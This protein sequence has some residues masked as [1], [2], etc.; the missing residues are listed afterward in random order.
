MTALHN[1]IAYLLYLQ[2]LENSHSNNADEI[3]NFLFDYFDENFEDDDEDDED[4]FNDVLEDQMLTLDVFY[5]EEQYQA[6][7]ERI[8]LLMDHII[9][10]EE[11]NDSIKE[12]YLNQCVSYLCD[13]YEET[14]DFDDAIM[15]FIKKNTEKYEDYVDLEDIVEM[16]DLD[17]P[18]VDEFEN[19]IHYIEIKIDNNTET[20]ENI[21]QYFFALMEKIMHYDDEDVKEYYLQECADR[22]YDLYQK[23][24][25]KANQLILEF[26][27]NKRV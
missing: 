21:V 19:M 24:D 9:S 13:L 12:N 2:E 20:T 5:E 17:P 1:A 14:D 6:Y 3:I 18:Y 25:P 16:E 10:N 7:F 8:L 4:G 27:K 26:I 15:D 11:Y 23:K 22:L